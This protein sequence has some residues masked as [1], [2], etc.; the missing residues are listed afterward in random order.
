ML[1]NSLTDKFVYHSAWN[2]IKQAT[3]PLKKIKL[4]V[5]TSYLQKL[6]TLFIRTLPP[7]QE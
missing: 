5:I 1:M 6:S 3:L 7:I 4:P 2:S